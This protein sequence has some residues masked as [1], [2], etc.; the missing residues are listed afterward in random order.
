ME[1]EIG[2]LYEVDIDDCCVRGNFTSKLIEAKD[3]NDDEELWDVTVLEYG[4]ELKFE[5]GV[6]LTAWNGVSLTLVEDE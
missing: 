5:N 4:T 2:K 6:N 3:Y 1:I